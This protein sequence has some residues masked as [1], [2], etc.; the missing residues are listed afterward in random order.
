M[1]EFWGKW[2]DILHF[3][4]WEIRPFM[5]VQCLARVDKLYYISI[6]SRVSKPKVTIK[7]QAYSFVILKEGIGV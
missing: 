4:S 5:S 6:Y 7:D 2:Y 3:R 1:C